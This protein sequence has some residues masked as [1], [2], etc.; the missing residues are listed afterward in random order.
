MRS[1]LLSLL[2]VSVSL[3]VANA[4]Q[5][6]VRDRLHPTVGTRDG[7]TLHLATDTWTRRANQAVATLGPDVL[8]DNSCVS[9]YF[10]ALSGDTYVDEGRLPSPSAPVPTGCSMNYRVDGFDIGYCTNQTASTFGALTYAFY[11]SYTPCTPVLNVT[12]TASFTLINL[13]ASSATGVQSCWAVTIDLTGS[14]GGSF[15]MAADGNG[16]F[17]GGT[18]NDHFGYAISSS[19]PG[20]TGLFIAGDP[21]VCP[22]GAGTAFSPTPGPGTGLGNLNSFFIHTTSTY[23][24]CHFFGGTP[25]K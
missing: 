12:P 2:V 14:G 3:P 1:A 5:S 19:S 10:S 23:T 25:K 9:G 17:Q 4:R 16:G 15:I 6:S 11:Q 7:G 8:Y 22:P 13:P 24:G 18:T 20:M 21:N